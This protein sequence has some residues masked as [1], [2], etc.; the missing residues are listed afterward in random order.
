MHR[1]K[2]LNRYRIRMQAIRLSEN[3]AWAK[4]GGKKPWKEEE[5]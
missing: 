5:A 3:Q 4:V 1:R 2:V